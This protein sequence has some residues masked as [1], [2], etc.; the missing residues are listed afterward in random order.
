MK[1][2]CPFCFR[3]ISTNVRGKICRHGF[4]KNRWIF[5]GDPKIDQVE[6]K[7]VDSSPCRGSGKVGLTLIQMQK[8]K[9]K[10]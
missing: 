6:Y 5:D 4:R 10:K 8:E 7:K 3:E 9:G 1:K 2:Y